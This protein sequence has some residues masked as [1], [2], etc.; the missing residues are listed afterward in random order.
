M[1][2]FDIVP[3]LKFVT[4]DSWGANPNLPRLGNRVQRPVRTHVFAHHTVIVDTDPSPNIWETEIEI[5]AM[6][7]KIQTVRPDLG[8]D[9]PYNFVVFLT[10][11]NDGIYVCEGRGEDRAG[12]HTKGH[13]TKAI[14]T[15]FAG[16]F[17]NRL[18]AP[19]E[20][21]RRIEL[22][23]QFLGWLKFSCSHPAYGQFEPLR[24]LGQL[25]PSGRNVFFHRDVAAT[26]CP[27][28]K[29]ESHLRRAT[30]TQPA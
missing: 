25:K 16:D 29:L 26:A 17:E 4:R 5:F 19:E 3:G 30:F 18:I 7:R 24:N 20:I 1:P 6:M 10:T 27:G 15:S 9:V 8:L 13:N 22:Y 11:I 28:S 14:A 23:S 21:E 12:A 2:A